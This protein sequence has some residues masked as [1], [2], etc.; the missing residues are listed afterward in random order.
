[1]PRNLNKLTTPPAMPEID[2]VRFR[3]IANTIGYIV[4]DD[5]SIYSCRR[6][7]GKSFAPTW[8]RMKPSRMKYGHLTVR[9]SFN[10]GIFITKTV[11]KIVKTAFDGPTPAGLEIRHLDGDPSNNRL[12]NLA[13]GTHAENGSDM[14]KHGSLKGSRCGNSKITEE[15]AAEI[16]RRLATGERH[17]DIAATVGIGKQA[18]SKI[19]RGINWSHVNV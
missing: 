11:H 6:E 16:K 9:I 3:C 10:G 13:W 1:M 17:A 12:S 7:K 19:K 18:I 15:I 2:G 4:G 8:R 14:A 5:G